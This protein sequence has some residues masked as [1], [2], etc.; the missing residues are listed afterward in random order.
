[1][2]QPI[3]R[4]QDSGLVSRSADPADGRVVQVRLT[5]RGRDLL[6]RRRAV[7]AGR[8]A[9][10]LARLTPEERAALGAALTAIDALAV[11]GA[12]ALHTDD[13]ARTKESTR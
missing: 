1:M 5:G 10:I 4:L 13:T 2:T 8:I 7:R 9:V 11:T 3:A 12:S 6:A